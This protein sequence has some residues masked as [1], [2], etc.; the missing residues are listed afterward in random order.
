MPLRLKT[1]VTGFFSAL[2]LF[3][4]AWGVEA[5]PVAAPAEVPISVP[6]NKAFVL[7]LPAP[8]QRVAVTRPE[9]AE[10]VVLAPDLIL[11]NGKS[12]GATSLLVWFEDPPRKTEGRNPE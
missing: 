12:V 5:G 9:I 1:A 3:G 10:A 8:A 7:R 4:G 6:V 2:L 11:I